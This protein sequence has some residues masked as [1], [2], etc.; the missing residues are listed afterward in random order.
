MF[1]G[2]SFVPTLLLA[3]AMINIQLKINAIQTQDNND[4]FYLGESLGW[5]TLGSFM[6]MFVMIILQCLLL[7]A[8][9]S[10]DKLQGQQ[11]HYPFLAQVIRF[12]KIAWIVTVCYPFAYYPFIHVVS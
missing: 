6:V 8:I 1:Y 7:F 5:I 10:S 12:R 11:E 2:L 3:W 4:H 9:P